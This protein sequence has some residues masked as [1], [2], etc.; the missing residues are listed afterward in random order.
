ME[1]IDVN[2]VAFFLGF[3]PGDN[4]SIHG[5]GRLI[6]FILKENEK[7]N[8]RFVLFCPEWS[9]ESVSLLLKDHKISLNCFEIVTTKKIPFGIKLRN[10]IAARRKKV[11]KE[12]K[13]KL[14]LK[15]VMSKV[16][17]FGRNLVANYMST[18]SRVLL[19]LKTLLF[20]LIGI[21]LL[22]FLI[23]AGVIKI[24]AIAKKRLAKVT[25]SKLLKKIS[26]VFRRIAGGVY[27]TLIDEELNNLV[28]LINKRKDIDICYIPSMA[29]P[30]IKNLKSIKILAAPDIVFYDF[31]TQYNGVNLIHRRIR[32]S[33]SSAD[34][35]ISYS[36]YV[37]EEHL[38]KM[39]GVKPEKIKVIKHANIDMS[40][41][42]KVP[43]S[44]KTYIS[45]SENAKQVINK[46]TRLNYH[47]GDILYN[48]DFE[49]LDYVIYST[50]YR[51]HKNIFNLI[52]AMKIVNKEMHRNIKLVLTG[53][54]YKQ[55]YIN[56]YIH[57]NHLENDIFVMHN[58]SS[59]LLAALNKLANCAVNPTLF[60]G[61]F[62]FTFSEAYSV[63]TPSIMSGITVVKAEID[64]Q[65]LEKLMLFNPFNPMSIA[66]KIVWAVENSDFLFSKQNAL[67]QKFNQ[68]NWGKVVNEYNELFE[69][70]YN[71]GTFI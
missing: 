56:D 43:R 40:R 18:S 52:K 70:N 37:K 17:N 61:G 49:Q 30:Q 60:E 57:L 14:F 7:K 39:C 13:T 3:G 46:Y 10:L 67:Y 21:L 48:C 27:Q 63:G 4:L 64:D 50:Q 11:A 5:I 8:D 69:K 44:I 38:V 68:R 47:P 9:R 16:K 53:D 20:A 65:E 58:I 71:N 55:S 26:P 35:L 12:S 62:P 24:I 41:Y 36:D 25:K 6:A 33:I 28:N 32:E 2:K 29:W 22:P 23:I 34:Q 51:S 66:Q 42:I 45:Q 54:I 31:P 59:E 15:K 19:I 1:E